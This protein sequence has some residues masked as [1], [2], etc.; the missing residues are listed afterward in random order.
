ML[1]NTKQSENT[2]M[3]VSDQ[4]AAPG[5]GV[6]AALAYRSL[7]DRMRSSTRGSPAGGCL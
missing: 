7:T 5:E 6:K 1:L 3:C 2:A 4:V